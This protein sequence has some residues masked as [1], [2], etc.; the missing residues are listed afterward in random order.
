[1][2]CLSPEKIVANRS[3]TTDETLPSALFP[4]D[5]N[6][7]ILQTALKSCMGI[8]HFR[9]RLL[10]EYIRDPLDA[11]QWLRSV[12]HRMIYGCEKRLLAANFVTT[13][14][15]TRGWSY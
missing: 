14:Y 12:T 13:P 2:N 7:S 4:H 15:N 1:M 11:A 5:P 6:K 8:R 10:S 9:Q 3:W